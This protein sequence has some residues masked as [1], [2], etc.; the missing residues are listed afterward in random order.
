MGVFILATRNSDSTRMSQIAAVVIIAFL[1]PAAFD[2]KMSYSYYLNLH[3]VVFLG[4]GIAGWMRRQSK[5]ML[6]ASIVAA[7]TFCPFLAFHPGRSTWIIFDWLALILAGWIL[8]DPIWMNYHQ[9][10]NT[11]SN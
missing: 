6:I 10:Q 11:D 9:K 8:I 7:L 4:F 5:P 2:S 3:W 1:F